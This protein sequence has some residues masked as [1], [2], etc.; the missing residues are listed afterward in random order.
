MVH[1]I[2][3]STKGNSIRY[4]PHTGYLGLTPVKIE[5]IVAT[6]RDP[7]QKL[8]PSKSLTV[9]VRCYES[10]IGRLGVLQSNVLVDYT[11]VLWTKPD[12]KEYEEI[13]DLEL[14]FRIY[15][16]VQVGGFSTSAFVEYRCIWRVEAMLNHSPIIGVGHRQVKATEIA[17]TRYDVPLPLPSVPTYRHNSEPLLN[18]QINKPRVPRINYSMNCP[19]SAVGPMDLVSVPLSL[20]PMDSS[21]VIRSATIL[22]ERRIQLNRVVSPASSALTYYPVP[23]SASSTDT[24]S[25]PATPA[26]SDTYSS[27]Q[28]SASNS[29]LTSSNPTITPNTYWT[30]STSLDSEARPLLPQSSSS[31]SIEV[32]PTK[33]IAH[34][35]AEVD[36]SGPFSKSDSSVWSKTLTFQW[37]TPKS[38]SRWAIGETIRSDLVSVRFFLRV[39]VV[40]A[41]ALGT[42]TIELEERELL[43][44]STNESE[45]KLALCKYNETSSS[46]DNSRSKSK[47]PRRSS[48]R[49][50]PDPPELPSSSS[51]SHKVS[52][53]SSQYPSSSR[54]RSVPRRPHTSAGPRD[55]VHSLSSKSNGQPPQAQEASLESEENQVSFRRWKSARAEPS[56]SSKA[57]VLG[58]VSAPR[59]AALPSDSSSNSNMSGSMSASSA[60]DS[61]QEPDDVRE[62][63]AELAQIEVRSRRSSD[64]LGF[65]S[66]KKRTSVDPHLLMTGRV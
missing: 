7:D 5:G 29:S 11:E 32:L 30:S 12:G 61:S 65:I 9:S 1:L 2:L 20:Q 55:K 16:P 44:I 6:K 41:T 13:G 35:I 3:T 33:T 23:P 51:H 21:V 40:V 14:P 37:P 58:S 47:S 62:W 39:K 24:S 27:N 36:T 10:R 52:S 49:P 42:E 22:V 8:L 43:V 50:D 28:A 15:L 45:R 46:S 64:M 59:V 34:T 4:W 25:Q 63:E 66:K 53:A 18:L 60:S 48:R 54:T 19:T 57:G 31:A 26:S 38:N 17:L 56:E